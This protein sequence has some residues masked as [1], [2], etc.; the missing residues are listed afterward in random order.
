MPMLISAI[1][2]CRKPKLLVLKSPTRRLSKT[3]AAAGHGRAKPRGPSSGPPPPLGPGPPARRRGGP[4]MAGACP[5]TRPATCPPGASWPASTSGTGPARR[6]VTASPARGRGSVS[7]DPGS[8]AARVAAAGRRC[9][10]A[11]SP[12][13][14]WGTRGTTGQAGHPAERPGAERAGGRPGGA[15]CRRPRCPTATTGGR[16]PGP[17]PSGAAAAVPPPRPPRGRRTRGRRRRR[18][19]AHAGGAVHALLPVDAPGEVPRGVP[20]A[21][22]PGRARGGGGGPGDGVVPRSTRG[23]VAA[24]GDPGRALRHVSDDAMPPARCDGLPCRD[25]TAGPRVGEVRRDGPDAP[26][27]AWRET[28]P[29]P[30]LEPPGPS[31]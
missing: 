7:P 23:D 19:D 1:F 20:P 16:S 10:P 22:R 5:T 15:P 11:G 28:V 9:S 12:L 21:V 24:P 3:S 17:T 31:D 30:D 6:P 29:R 26:G 2:S 13:D 18:Q 27:L 4:S 25:G 8:L 14:G